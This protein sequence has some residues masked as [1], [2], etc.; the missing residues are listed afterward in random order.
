MNTA[1]NAVFKHYK[2]CDDVA[3][4]I[5]QKVH[6]GNQEVINNHISVI[7]NWN[8]DFDYWRFNNVRLSSSH[9]F[10]N[11]KRFAYCYRTD[12]LVKVMNFIKEHS[13]YKKETSNK[14][15]SNE[16]Y[17]KYIWSGKKV[18]SLDSIT[19]FPD[20]I[21]FCLKKCNQYAS[22]PDMVELS[23]TLCSIYS[24]HNHEL[25]EFISNMIEG[26]LEWKRRQILY[27]ARAYNVFKTL[28]DSGVIDPL[29][30]K[31][32]I[33]ND[34]HREFSGRQNPYIK[35]KITKKNLIQFLNQNGDSRKLTSKSKPEL[36]K[37]AIKV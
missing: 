37:M 26:Q 27:L 9:L 12:F 1:M 21:V 5:C 31:F 30:M 33:N 18:F 24:Y 23:R 34:R 11:A 4:I 17:M 19:R 29:T 8:E 3:Q 20:F 25:T 7:V 22:N 35:Y 36:W 14:L 32:F 6:K 15:M 10:N 16:D 28:P 2:V 13:C